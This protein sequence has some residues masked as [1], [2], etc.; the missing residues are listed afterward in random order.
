MTSDDWGIMEYNPSVRYANNVPPNPDPQYYASELRNLWNF[1][2]HVIVPFAWTDNSDL[3]LYDIKDGP[4]QKALRNLIN[5]IGK[6]PWFSWR[7]MLQ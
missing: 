3:K 2:L 6:T 5:S 1:R 4:F 7:V